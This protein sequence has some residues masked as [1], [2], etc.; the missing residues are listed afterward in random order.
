MDHLV[1]VNDSSQSI[2]SPSIQ[3][4]DVYV[5]RNRSELLRRAKDI[6]IPIHGSVT[7]TLMA[8]Y[9]IDSKYFQ[10][11]IRLNQLGGCDTIFPGAKHTRFE[12]SIGTYYLATRLINKI[13]SESDN[14]KIVEWL[15]DIP[16]LKSH[17]EYKDTT[18][19]P[20]L[21]QWVM[22]LVKI[23]ALCHD[24]GHGPYSHTFDDIF[25]K[26]SDLADHPMARH[27]QRSCMLVETI[28]RESHVLSKF[29]TNADILFIQSL[30]D[31]SPE[32]KGFIYQIVSNELNGLDVDKFDYINRDALHSGIKSGF[33]FPRLID[34]V[35]VIDNNIVY[36]EQAEYDIYNMFTTRHAMHQKLYGHKGVISVQYIIIEMMT[37]INKVLDI[38]GSITDPK[39]FVKLTDGYILYYVDFILDMRHDKMNPFKDKLID[40]DYDNL[41]ML[42]SRMQTHNL[43]PHVGTLSTKNKI[44]LGGLFDDDKHMIYQNKIGYV[45]G[46]KK[47]PLD[48]VYVY[49]TKDFFVNRFNAKMYKINKTEIS[50][51]M[52][53]NYQEYVLMVFRR[54]RDPDGLTKDKELFQSFKDTLNDGKLIC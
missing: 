45:S 42:Q 28:V 54:D 33:D 49:K 43:Y 1:A 47:N 3:D 29:I 19:A 26:N 17:Y 21:D 38:A 11:L 35:L 4:T 46:N 6:H 44:D 51:I 7:I 15:N 9:F 50:N 37:I 40:A 12:H 18:T 30:I 5:I 48:N 24:I 14:C 34:A 22:E 27:E 2:K 41:E 53:E 39:R 32:Q 8:K 52:P 20:G 16:E 13:K 31:P 10:R 23:A 25:I 36:P